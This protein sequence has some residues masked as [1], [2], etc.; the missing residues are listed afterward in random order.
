MTLTVKLHSMELEE[1]CTNI[2]KKL[3]KAKTVT[4]ERNFVL[5]NSGRVH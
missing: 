5:N 4:K 2:N 3:E 1:R